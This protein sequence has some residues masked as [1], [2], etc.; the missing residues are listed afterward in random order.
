MSRGRRAR[1]HRTIDRF[2]FARFVVGAAGLVALNVAM[3]LLIFSIAAPLVLGWRP[4]AIV[5]SSMEPTISEGDVV[6]ID[7]EAEI[8]VGAVVTYEDPDGRG[9]ITHRVIEIAD[10][11]DLITRGDANTESDST[12][13]SVDAVVGR[14]RLLIPMAGIPWLWVADKNWPG[15]IGIL[16]TLAVSTWIGRW[17]LMVRAEADTYR[18]RD[19]ELSLHNDNRQVEK[20]EEFDERR[21]SVL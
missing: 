7:P 12:P 3:W 2:P 19:V 10:D 14:G 13:I 18:L 17:A 1:R 20:R 15:V 6:V 5:S 4:V 21:S 8:T 9:L 11:G 16:V